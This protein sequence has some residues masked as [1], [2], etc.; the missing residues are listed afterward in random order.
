MSRG[1]KK[2]TPQERLKRIMS[3]QLTKQSKEKDGRI[4]AFPSLRLSTHIPPTAHKAHNTLSEK[5]YLR[6]YPPLRTSLHS[7]LNLTLSTRL[8]LYTSFTSSSSAV[9]KDSAAE[10]A[11]KADVDRQLQDRAEQSR[12]QARHR[13]PTRSRSRSRS[14]S[15]TPSP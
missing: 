12:R 11:K 1:E 7:I 5:V 6:K 13:T 2:E 14:R 3:K 10:S 15:R 8:S 4:T 9:K